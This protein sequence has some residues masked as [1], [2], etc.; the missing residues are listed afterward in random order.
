VTAIVRRGR[1]H[2]LHPMLLDPWLRH[3]PFEVM[4][5]PLDLAGD[6][7]YWAEDVE[8]LVLWVEPCRVLEVV[9]H[10]G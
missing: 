7:V 10:A 3:L 4:V 5:G 2:A 9:I 1:T 6:G 8:S